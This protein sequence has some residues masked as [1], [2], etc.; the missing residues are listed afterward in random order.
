MSV[1]TVKSGLPVTV[2]YTREG[3]GMIATK[4][5]VRKAAAPGVIIQKKTTVTEESR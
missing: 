2:H 5:I 3:D 4:V 1:E